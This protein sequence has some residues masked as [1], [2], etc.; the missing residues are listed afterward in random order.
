MN[1]QDLGPGVLVGI[2]SD[3]E[4]HAAVSVVAAVS[5]YRR[6]TAAALYAFCTPIPATREASSWHI[7]VDVRP[8]L[9]KF[10]A[11]VHGAETGYRKFEYLGV[12][13]G[14]RSEFWENPAFSDGQGGVIRYPAARLDNPDFDRPNP[15][16]YGRV[17]NH[18]NSAAQN[19]PFIVGKKCGDVEVSREITE[20]P[21]Y[22]F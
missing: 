12:L 18:V 10:A 22:L 13:N 21:K 6:V 19:L 4:R 2:V 9:A 11:I 17:W 16:T 14:F 20:E 3:D 15:A 7:P 8:E 5:R 1:P